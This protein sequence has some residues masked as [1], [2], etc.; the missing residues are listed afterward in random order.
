MCVIVW[1]HSGHE[2][3]L[4]VVV[5]AASFEILLFKIGVEQDTRTLRSVVIQL[6]KC[7]KMLLK[8]SE[9]VLSCI[10]VPHICLFRFQR[11]ISRKVR[12]V[13]VSKRA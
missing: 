9:R 4:N 6:Q 5:S 1:A 8:L 11:I 2:G 10:P 13:V 12:F 7:H 3:L